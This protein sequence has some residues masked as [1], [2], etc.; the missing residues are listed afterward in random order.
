MYAV[1]QHPVDQHPVD[2][3][4]VGLYSCEFVAFPQECA[5]FTFKY[6]HELQDDM[7]SGWYYLSC[8]CVAVKICYIYGSNDMILRPVE[9][10]GDSVRK[11]LGWLES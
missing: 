5:G 1:D 4:P 10:S 2:R 6:L 11:V 8:S 3:H 9:E 7:K